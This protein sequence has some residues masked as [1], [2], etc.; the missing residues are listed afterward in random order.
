MNQVQEIIDNDYL[1][2]NIKRLIEL[3]YDSV[4]ECHSAIGKVHEDVFK[5]KLEEFK[6]DHSIQALEL[7]ELLKMREDIS[8]VMTMSFLKNLLTQGKI[9]LANFGGD[10]SLLR[11]IRSSEIMLT[12]FYESVINSEDMTLDW[13][14][15]LEKGLINGKRHIQ[16]LDECLATH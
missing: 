5:N 16:W 9:A 8:S 11:A 4:E 15:V 3:N 6:A 13:W 1:L 7:A 14:S 10:K 2:D 12:N